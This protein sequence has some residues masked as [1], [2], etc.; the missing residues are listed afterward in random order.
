MVLEFLR[1]K[2]QCFIL[3]IKFWKKSKKKKLLQVFLFFVSCVLLYA[4]DMMTFCFHFMD[5]IP[6]GFFFMIMEFGE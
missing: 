1:E 3:K 5:L 4:D 6:P 2:T